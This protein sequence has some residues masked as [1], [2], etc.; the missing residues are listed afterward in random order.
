MQAG[1]TTRIFLESAEKT[2]QARATNFERNKSQKNF[3]GR[4]KTLFIFKK[5]HFFLPL[6][7]E[8]C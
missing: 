3:Y 1:L 4:K 6:L 8:K 5:S 7:G 2:E